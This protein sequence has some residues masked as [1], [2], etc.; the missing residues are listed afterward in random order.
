MAPPQHPAAITTTNRAAS[1]DVS[2]AVERDDVVVTARD[3][4]GGEPCNLMLSLLVD[5]VDSVVGLQDFIFVVSVAWLFDPLFVCI[6]L[7]GNTD[8]SWIKCKRVNMHLKILLLREC[9]VLLNF[10][11]VKFCIKLATSTNRRDGVCM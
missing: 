3:A 7:D 11:E 10:G 5:F 4:I 9:K 8:K 1:R 2:R 6:V